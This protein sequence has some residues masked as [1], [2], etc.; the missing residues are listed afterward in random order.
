MAEDWPDVLDYRTFA[1]VP[2]TVDDVA[3]ADALAAVQ[4]A[5]RARCPI[6]FGATPSVPDAVYQAALLWT[7]RVLSRRNSPDG[8]VGVGEMGVAN[9]G[10]WDPDVQRLL[11]PYTDPVLA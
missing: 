10:R 9:V 2:D 3:I 7:A 8:I 6:L 11:A 4:D 1:R 5:I